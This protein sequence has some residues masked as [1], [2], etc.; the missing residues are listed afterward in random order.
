MTTLSGGSPLPPLAEAFLEFRPG[1]F[2]LGELLIRQGYCSSDDVSFALERQKRESTR[3]GE[4]LVGAGVCT[5]PQIDAALEAQRLAAHPVWSSLE[6]LAWHPDLRTSPVMEGQRELIVAGVAPLGVYMRFDAAEFALAEAIATSRTYAEILNAVWH[7]QGLL[8]TPGQVADLGARLWDAGLLQDPDA[9]TAT[10]R[11]R[12]GLD[13]LIWRLP[14]WDPSRL[15]HACLPV[16]KPTSSLGFLSAVWLPIALTAA[17]LGVLHASEV[18]AEVQALSNQYDSLHLGRIYALLFL[19]LAVHEF[20]HAA[21]ST[22]LGATVRQMG[23]MLFIGMPFGFCDTSEAHRL[24]LRGR[25]A[26]SLA[27][28]YYQF[29]LAALCMLAWAWL[30]LTTG[31]RTLALDLAIISVAAGAFNLIPFARLD[32]YYLTEDLLALPNLQARAFSY[33]GKK[34]TGRPTGSVPPREAA[35]LTIY[36]LLGLGTVGLLAVLAFRFWG[37][38]LGL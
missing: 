26:V 37:K 6:R 9:P 33:I 3:L 36:G 31:G 2:R 7:S 22:A 38:H 21:V 1:V 4:L 15:L 23:V 13:W 34:L 5:K 12:S 8:I 19:S 35:I 16:L 27:G 30:P 29:G 18:M 14:L 25:V 28:L 11:R 17:A 32:G 20:G 10:G 24:S